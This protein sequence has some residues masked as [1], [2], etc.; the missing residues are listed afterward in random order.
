[1]QRAYIDKL[2]AIVVTPAGT[3]PA[4]PGFPGSTTLP[5]DARALARL[6]L[7][8]IDQRCAGALAAKTALGDYTR[9]HLLESR[10][11]IKRALEAQRT[12]DQPAGAG[13]GHAF[14]SP[15]SN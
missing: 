6:Q 8:R 15:T 9:A 14:G 5:D 13:G 2:A 12:A 3:T 4:F 7:Q 11:R 1:V 10:A